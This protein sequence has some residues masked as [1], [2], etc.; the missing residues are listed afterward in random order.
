ML[1]AN[2]VI[3]WIEG[4]SGPWLY[5]VA[6]VLAFAE[7]GTLLFFVPGEFTL[8]LAGIATQKGGLS[9]P[10]MLVIGCAAAIA[11]DATG[12][13]IGRK[14]GPKLQTSWLGRK[15]GVEN[16]KKS[17]D[18]MRRRR[19][20]IVLVGRWIGFLR[21]I[22]PATAGMSGLN[23]KKDFLVYDVVGAVSWATLCILGGWKLGEKAEQIVKQ[24]G[25]V[26]VGAFVL[27]VAWFAKKK[28]TAKFAG[29]S[30]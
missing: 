29:T 17:E 12:F 28:L 4:V 7:T 2:P 19:G 22:M 23:Y 9:L 21:A 27:A 11:G 5:A 14:F 3:K 30:S 13:W 20:V 18:L 1:A 10:L 26:A 6:G 25:W 16:W 15:L 24:I 8:I